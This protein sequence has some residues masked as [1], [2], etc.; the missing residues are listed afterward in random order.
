MTK[1]ANLATYEIALRKEREQTQLIA[2]AKRKEV[3]AAGGN[4]L[5]C[6]HTRLAVGKRLVCKLKDKLV[7]QFNYCDKFIEMKPEGDNDD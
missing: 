1:P 5:L 3:Q 4:C 6:K 2:A 7:T